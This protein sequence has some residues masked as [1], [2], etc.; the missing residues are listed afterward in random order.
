MQNAVLWKSDIR[1]SWK[2]QCVS[3]LIHGALILLVLLYPWNDGYWPVWLSLVTLVIFDCLRS[4]RH[5]QRMQGEMA[6]LKNG[7]FQWH[8]E[9]WRIKGRPMML[10]WGVFLTIQA[11]AGRRNRR[12]LWLAVDSMD[13]ESW[14]SLR[15]HLQQLERQHDKR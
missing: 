5:I 12:R 3:L 10:K 2:S 6:L 15:F 1:I 11:T 7:V 13:Q 14:R 4:Q 9:E 8:R